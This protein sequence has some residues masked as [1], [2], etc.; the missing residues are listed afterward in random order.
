MPVCLLSF[1][2]NKVMINPK[3]PKIK[4]K[5]VSHLFFVDGSD[6]TCYNKD[7]QFGIKTYLLPFGISHAVF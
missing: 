6:L 4:K 7:I 3:P 5:G 1:N 2:Y